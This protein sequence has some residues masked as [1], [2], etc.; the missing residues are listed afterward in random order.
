MTIQPSASSFGLSR[1]KR[2]VVGRSPT[3]LANAAMKTVIALLRQATPSA[4]EAARRD[5]A[6]DRRWGTDTSRQIG[7]NALD[8]PTALKKGSFHYQASGAHILDE[9]I[10][11][12][13]IDPADFTFIDYG[14][15]KGR[16]VLL[17][18]AKPFARAIGV[19]YSALLTEIA[20]ANSVAFAI[21]GGATLVPEF[22]QGNA[23]DYVPPEGPLF[24]YLYNSFGAEILAG[25]LDRLEAAKASDPARRI[26]LAYINPQFGD[27]VAARSCWHESA[28]GYD[29][30]VFECVADEP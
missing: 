15:G 4:R 7:M 1:V 20:Q 25:C 13:G 10:M 23:A 2:G 11:V 6:F 17:A 9:T 8:F 24:C 26:L 14:C 29:I 3:Q 28:P 19:E 18:A 5:Q 30:R 27:F 12:A 16:I 22:W 21:R